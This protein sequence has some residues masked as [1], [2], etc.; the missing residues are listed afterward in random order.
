LVFET[1]S[2]GSTN[3]TAERMRITSAGNVGIG[4]SSPGAR[5][6]VF[7]SDGVIADAVFTN[8]AAS[9][10]GSGAALIL[11]NNDGAANASG[12]RL[13]TM[14]FRGAGDASG[15]IV[16]GARISAF[17]EANFTTSSSPTN[18]RFETTPTGSTGTF[19]RMRIDSS[20]NLLVGTTSVVNVTTGSND[21]FTV[22]SSGRI[23]ASLN[24][25]YTLGLRRRGND[26]AVAAFFRDTTNVGTISVTATNTA[27]NTSSDYRLKEDWQPMQGAITRL[28]QLKPVNFAWKVDGSRVD[29]FLAHE[30]QEIIP[31]AVTGTKDAV[32][33][34]GKP[35]Y[36]GIDQSKLVPLLTAALQEAVAEINALKAR[37]DAANL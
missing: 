27:Y 29:G 36:Q 30:V 17:A 3:T 6:A 37:L 13:T 19:E 20:G 11:Q 21:G 22:E 10:N 8:T 28:N 5:L 31:A 7:N 4:T 18:L 9:S 14:I 24:S 2:D 33:A 35:E 12:D 1:K 15:T 16:T 26:G 25:G 23:N 32:D 34:D